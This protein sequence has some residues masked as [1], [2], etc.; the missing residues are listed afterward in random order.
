VEDA[1]V[2]KLGS[3]IAES[4]AAVES[5]GMDLSVQTRLPK[6]QPSGLGEQGRKQRLA[7][8]DAACSR[9]HGHPAD[10]D[11]SRL[12]SVEPARSGWFVV[13]EGQGVDGG[14]IRAIVLVDLDFGRDPLL[15]DENALPDRYGPAEPVLIIDVE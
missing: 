1:R 2:P 9:Q 15:F 10:L 13:D 3:V 12:E 7:D 4:G 5:G 14:R 8:T 6:A 11:H